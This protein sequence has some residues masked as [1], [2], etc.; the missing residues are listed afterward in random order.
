MKNSA[1]V[2]R[3]PSPRQA[4][5]SLVEMIGVLA[6]IAILAV[7][8]VPKVFSTIASSRVTSTVG[9]VNSIKT[10][11]AEF[12]GKYGTLPV[13]GSTT[14]VVSLTNARIDDL[15]MRTQNLESRFAPK[16]GSQV[17]TNVA[18]AT[19]TQ[20]ATTGAWQT[21]GGADQ[22]GQSRIITAV[23]NTATPATGNNYRLNGTTNLPTNSIVASAVIKN[24]TAN[25][26]RELSLRIDSET[27]SQ[28]NTT[29][30]DN[31]GK[32]VYV[33]PVNGVTDVYIYA[34]HQ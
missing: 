15:L 25:D 10:A 11:L 20:N 29:T 18:G 3:S 4:G 12:S 2:V 13:L 8:I 9:S 34:A 31:R 5:F 28:T 23:S 22:T 27:L 16:I 30:A 21:A 1:F 7:V 33:A 26:A 32:V 6:I 24:V 14:P 17:A 19:W